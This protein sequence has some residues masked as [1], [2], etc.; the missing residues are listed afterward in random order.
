MGSGGGKGRDGGR[1]LNRL[2]V[3]L[4]GDFDFAD[5]RSGVT[6]VMVGGEERGQ[7]AYR[8]ARR[9]APGRAVLSIRRPPSIG[10]CSV[11]Q[12]K[13]TQVE[14]MEGERCSG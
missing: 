5:R 2:E 13:K 3:Y 4:V 14:D 11:A 10:R 6:V 8:L 12:K 1:K 9:G 7:V